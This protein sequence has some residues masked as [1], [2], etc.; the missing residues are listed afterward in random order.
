MRRLHEATKTRRLGN[1]SA[2]A[3]G[4][5]KDNEKVEWCWSL[6]YPFLSFLS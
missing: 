4:N 2:M 3:I 5:D 6:E 1:V